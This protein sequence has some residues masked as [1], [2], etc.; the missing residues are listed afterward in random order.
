MTRVR[1]IDTNMVEPCFDT[2]A[3]DTVGASS[4]I[5]RAGRMV[6]RLQYADELNPAQWESLRFQAERE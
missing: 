2:I 5:E 1:A 4:L 6:R 3:S